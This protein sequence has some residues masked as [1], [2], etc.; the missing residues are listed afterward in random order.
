MTTTEP[1]LYYDPYDFEIDTDPVPDLEAPPGRGPLYYNERYDFY[2]L[3]RFDDVERGLGRL[4]APTARRKG[5]LL[6]LIKSG[7]EIP[8]GSIIFEDPPSHDLHRGLLSRV[9]TPKKMNAIEPKVREFCARSLDPLVGTGGFDFIADL[10]AQMPM[11]TI[12]MLLGIPEQDQEAHPR[13]HRRGPAP[14]GRHDARRRRPPTRRRPGRAASTST[15]TG[16]PST[17]PTT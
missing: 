3:S 10:G 5:T 16:G 13:P 14:R 7:I 1:E 4:E 11:R 9:F 6:E 12:G 15:S 17:R 8:P 2:A